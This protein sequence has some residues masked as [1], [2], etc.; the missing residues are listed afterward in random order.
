[1]PAIAAKVASPPY[2]V[3]SR[4]EAV[5]LARGNPFSFLHV[6]RAEI[7]LPPGTNPYD[8]KVYAKARQNL[9]LLYRE[10]TFERDA[11]PVVYVY[12][13][14]WQG[15]TQAGV[16]GCFHVDDY[17]SNAIR[18][19]ELTRPDKEDDRTRHILALNAHAEP[20]LLAHPAQ[21]YI[22]QLN[23]KAQAATPLFDFEADDGVRHRIWRSQDAAPYV[24]AIRRLDR[25]YVADGHHR[26][27]SAVRAAQERRKAN[28]K[29]TGD[30][31]YNWFLGVLF[32]AP[33]LRILPYHRVVRDLN[34]LSAD[35]FRNRLRTLGA[36]EPTTTPLPDR[37]GM[38]GIRLGDAWFRLA[39]DPTLIDA[40]DP[41]QSLDA[42][43]LQRHILEPI[44][45]ITDVRTDKRIDFVGGIRGVPELERRVAGGEAAVAF[46]MHP[47]AFEQLM[48]IADAGAIMPPKSTWFEPKLRSGLFVHALD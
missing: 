28:P 23:A 29:H 11:A 33:Q 20:V 14:T 48:T 41:V 12:E 47:V 1:V 9:D 24:D 4:D 13:L 31:E 6:V 15:R 22:G 10:G 27:A 43:I 2:D 45:G 26:S 3:V 16:V 7:D 46:A 38:F 40:R 34:G 5:E 37:P 25:V 19:H 39:M 18:K 32:P 44:L 42:S 21:P 17:A 35:E 36:L 30:E 8:E